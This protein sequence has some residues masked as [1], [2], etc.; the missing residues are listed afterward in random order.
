M[1]EN[2]NNEKINILESR[3][4]EI[5][6]KLSYLGINFDYS[7]NNDGKLVYNFYNAKKL[8]HA[9]FLLDADNKKIIYQALHF[10]EN[11]F[12]EPGNKEE[13]SSDKL[14][15]YLSEK[16]PNTD[17]IIFSCC[18]PDGARISFANADDKIIFIGTG[19]GTYSTHYNEKDKVLSSVKN[20]K[21]NKE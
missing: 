10:G 17:N 21:K 5:A 15:Q 14:V 16:F 12:E 18:N 7:I 19:T 4:Q 3:D 11:I 6:D 9:A 2:I 8:S 1:E 20:T 13:V